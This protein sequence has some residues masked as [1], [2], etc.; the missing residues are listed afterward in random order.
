LC[1][2][3]GPTGYVGLFAGVGTSGVTTLV[4]PALE[5]PLEARLEFDASAYARIG[6]R[7]SASWN[8]G[9]STRQESVLASPWIHELAFGAFARFG[10]TWTY[11][12]GGYAGS[13][14]FIA[15]ERRELMG[16]AWLGLSF[17]VETDAAW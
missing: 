16:S 9:T 8:V 12:R 11:E 5:I 13:G 6:F 14:W 17:G 3:F 4:E 10:K 7:A 1:A 2:M 15:L